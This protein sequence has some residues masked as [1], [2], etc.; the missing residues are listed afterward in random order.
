MRKISSTD[1]ATTPKLV[2]PAGHPDLFWLSPEEV[3][4]VGEDLASQASGSR[5]SASTSGTH[6]SSDKA[7]D[8]AAAVA[9]E[10]EESSDVPQLS[11]IES[12]V[13]TKYFDPVS[14]IEKAKA[15]IKIRNSSKN[16]E[17]V[18]GVD[19]RMLLIRGI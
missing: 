11:D 9:E 17:S 5:V 13:F 2:R 12:V 16:K 4:V 3:L 7:A 8:S 14:K 1:I 15:V 18:A 6:L 10:V 19:A